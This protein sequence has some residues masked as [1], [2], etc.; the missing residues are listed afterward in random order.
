MST[1]QLRVESNLQLNWCSLEQFSIECRK[2]SDMD[3][4]RSTSLCD[5]SRQPIRCKTET[6]YI[7]VT[8]IFPLSFH[9]FFKG[10]FLFSDWPLWQLWFGFATLIEKRPTTRLSWS[11][12][13][14]PLSWQVRCKTE[15][16]CNL[17]S[18]IFPCFR[19]CAWFFFEISFAL[20]RVTSQCPHKARFN[21]IKSKSAR[22]WVQ[23][24]EK[25]ALVLRFV[26]S[27]CHIFAKIG[28]HC[29]LFIPS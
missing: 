18:R 25:V 20:S 5:W 19:R 21:L 7:L 3:W 16:N 24:L 29:S 4:F 2:L 14:A 22:A 8:R 27:P 9:W 12:K 10:I 13:I 15:K 11:G 28:S 6:N 1:F 26:W 17:F 23:P